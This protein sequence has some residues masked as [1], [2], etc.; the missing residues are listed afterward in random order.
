MLV[1]SEYTKNV[2]GILLWDKDIVSINEDIIKEL[3]SRFKN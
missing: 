3:A 1:I 2:V